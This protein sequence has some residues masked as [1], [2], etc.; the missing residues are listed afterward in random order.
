MK[1][2]GNNEELLFSSVYMDGNKNDIIPDQPVREAIE[3]STNSGIPMVLGADCNAHHTL[4]GSSDVNAN[5]IIFVVFRI[6]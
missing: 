3:F 4:W 2:S 5:N 6:L 1:E